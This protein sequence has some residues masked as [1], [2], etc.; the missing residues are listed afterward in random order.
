MPRKCPQEFCEHGVRIVLEG[1][2]EDKSL[3]PFTVIEQVG[4]ELGVASEALTSLT[5]RPSTGSVT[6]HF[7]L[8]CIPRS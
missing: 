6:T 7:S 8:T 4:S 1:L 5:C 2:E 3:A